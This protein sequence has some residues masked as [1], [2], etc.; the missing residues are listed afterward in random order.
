MIKRGFLK[1]MPG[2]NKKNL[3]PTEKAFMLIDALPDEMTYPDA[4]AIWEDKLHS[5]SEGDG[6]LDEFLAGQIKFTAELVAK[7]ENANIKQAEGIQCPRC[8]VG[9]MV[10]RTGKNGAFW[11]CSNF[12]RC[13]MSCDDK[14]GKPDFEGKKNFS[15]TDFKPKDF[16]G[17]GNIMSSADFINFSRKQAIKKVDDKEN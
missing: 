12:P 17:E 6:T 5:M 2:K 16:F 9:V 8:K 13:R 15:P 4:T 3:Q 14:D 10:K 7:A 1:F 11:G